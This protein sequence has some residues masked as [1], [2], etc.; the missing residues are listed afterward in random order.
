MDDIVVDDADT[1]Q[2]VK[3]WW[4]KDVLYEEARKKI[5]LKEL[6]KNRADAKEKAI[7]MLALPGDGNRHRFKVADDD[8][9]GTTI[10]VTPGGDPTPVEATTRKKNPQFR[11]D[12]TKP[13]D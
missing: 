3:D 5:G 1:V 10:S 8:G 2:A 11:L 6:E 9:W 13:A 12:N 7:G 4:E